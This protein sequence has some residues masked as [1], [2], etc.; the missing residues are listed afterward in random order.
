MIKLSEDSK[1]GLG[2]AGQ[3]APKPVIH[4][5][6][7]VL[8]SVLIRVSSTFEAHSLIRFFGSAA[9]KLGKLTF[10]K[11]VIEALNVRF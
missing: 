10:H 7:F 11:Q 4:V 2:D 1:A 5:D 8:L 9:T 6:L 3:V